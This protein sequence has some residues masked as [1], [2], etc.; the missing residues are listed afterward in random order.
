MQQHHIV[1]QSGPEG[2]AAFEAEV[3]RIFRIEADMDMNLI[4]D[5]AEPTTGRLHVLV[6]HGNHHLSHISRIVNVS[7]HGGS[8]SEWHET[9]PLKA[10][11]SFKAGNPFN[12]T[13][14]DD[15]ET[16]RYR[17]RS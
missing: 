10:C 11:R 4:F 6:S 15:R 12:D 3:R 1:A 8:L 14:K 5:C 9:A 2:Y 16:K 13:V 17:D 7:N